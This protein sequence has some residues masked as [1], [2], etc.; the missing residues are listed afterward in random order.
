MSIEHPDNLAE[1]Q[2][3]IAGL[4]GETLRNKAIA[5]NSYRFVQ[6]LQEDG[7][8][9]QDI[10]EVLRMI[11]RQ[12]VVTGQEPVQDG[13]VDYK[14]LIAEDPELNA[15]YETLDDE[16]P[17]ANRQRLTQTLPH[18]WGG[19]MVEKAQDKTAARAPEGLYGYPKAIQ[20]ACESA[21]RKLK[22]AAITIAKNAYQK[23]AKVIEFLTA[24]NKRAQSTPARVLLAALKESAPVLASMGVKG[25]VPEKTAGRARYGLY[26]FKARTAALGLGACSQLRSHAGLIASDLHTRKATMH[27]RL[28]GF[29]DTHAKKARCG[30]SRMLRMAYPDASMKLASSEPETVDDWLAWD[31]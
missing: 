11:A 26:G 4:E 8:S 15:L 3:H 1:W 25:G 22:K 24:H 14:A 2:D 9:A 30:Y 20:A 29:F 19:T 23:D 13:Y 21:S 5:A 17:M 31:E 18:K 16:D 27:E 6:T 28:T 12:F 7:F 10:G